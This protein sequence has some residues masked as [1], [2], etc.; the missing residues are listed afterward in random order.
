[1]IT[2]VNSYWDTSEVKDGH[3]PYR[4]IVLSDGTYH[5]EIDC[6]KYSNGF[7]VLNSFANDDFSTK[8]VIEFLCG[9]FEDGSNLNDGLENIL[10]PNKRVTAI[11]IDICGVPVMVSSFDHDADKIYNNWDENYEN[12]IIMLRNI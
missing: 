8:D 6:D 1:M 7:L 3:G 10:G 4:V 5:L 2:Q 12:Y 9:C 11:C